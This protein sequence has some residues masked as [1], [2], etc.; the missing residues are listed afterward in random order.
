MTK[1]VLSLLLM[2]T[3][4]LSFFAPAVRAADADQIYIADGSELSYLVDSGVVSLGES[5]EDN[6]FGLQG[7]PSLEQVEE[8][9][10]VEPNCS[11]GQLT[12]A[13]QAHADSCALKQFCLSVCQGNLAQ[14]AAEFEDCSA[15]VRNALVAYLS[16]AMPEKLEQINALRT[17]EINDDKYVAPEPERLSGEASAVYEDVTVGAVGV[18]E[19]SSLTVAEPSAEAVEAVQD[20][21]AQVDVV[22]EE[23][24]VYDISV[25][26]SQ[27]RDW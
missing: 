26:N 19:G 14:I 5:P 8:E 7:L 25:Q 24:F 4:V 6:N 23:L 17:G 12:A 1:R 20:Y 9:P 21:V 15:D 22:P 27:S 10:S 13:V 3:M 11:C 2:L 16:A 18:P